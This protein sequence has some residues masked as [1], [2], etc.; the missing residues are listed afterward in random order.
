MQGY[1]NWFLSSKLKLY[2]LSCPSL[3]V[4]QDDEKASWKVIATYNKQLPLPEI[5]SPD[6]EN[7]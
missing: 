7:I 2:L 5:S 1:K 4:D 6:T 3:S